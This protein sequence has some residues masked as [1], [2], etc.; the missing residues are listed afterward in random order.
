MSQDTFFNHLF[1]IGHFLPHD[2]YL[3][4]Q[5]RHKCA[6]PL[7]Q[8]VEL[9]VVGSHIALFKTT[10][11]FNIALVHVQCKVDKWPTQ[12]LMQQLIELKQEELRNRTVIALCFV[13]QKPSR[14]RLLIRFGDNSRP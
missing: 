4:L 5:I 14:P 12:Q 13:K 7:S 8:L 1:G 9:Y 6:A 10:V 11:Q 3:Q 2:V